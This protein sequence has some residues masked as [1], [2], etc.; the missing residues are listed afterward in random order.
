MSE[1]PQQVRSLN[2]QPWMQ[3]HTVMVWEWKN[4][5]KSTPICQQVLY[6]PP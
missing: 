5:K 3:G 4:E 2:S 6:P 1:E